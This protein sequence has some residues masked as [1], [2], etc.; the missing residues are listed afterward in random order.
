MKSFFV[1][2]HISN[3]H[4]NPNLKKKQKKQTKIK[5]IL[6]MLVSSLQKEDEPALKSHQ[7]S[8]RIFHFHWSLLWARSYLFCLSI[9]FIFRDK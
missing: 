4:S 8:N 5:N 7:D 3:K 6:K 2:I 1:Y 9:L